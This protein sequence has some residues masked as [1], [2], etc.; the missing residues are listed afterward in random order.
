MDPYALGPDSIPWA[1]RA[2]LLVVYGLGSAWWVRAVG[3]HMRA[4][5]LPA[6]LLA[7]VL[8]ANAAV[9]L[10]FEPDKEVLS[11]AVLSFIF[12]WLANAKM[13]AFYLGRGPLARHLDSGFLPFAAFLLLPLLPKDTAHGEGLRDKEATARRVSSKHATLALGKAVLLMAVCLALANV[14]MPH[15]P[16]DLLY[17]LG[18]YGLLG[19]IMDGTCS[20][21]CMFGLELAPH[22]DKPWLSTSV[23]EFW[24]R[25]WNL[26]AADSLRALAF[27]P[28]REGRLF[29]VSPKPAQPRSASSHLLATM[30]GVLLTFALSGLFHGATFWHLTRTFGWRWLAFFCLQGPLVIIERF[31]VRRLWPKMPQIVAILYAIA[32]LE[33]GGRYLFIAPAEDMGLDR[34]VVK[35]ILDL[36]AGMFGS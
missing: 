6:A 23:A 22:F 20:L 24:G 4:G 28:L 17:A 30:V 35:A 7:P 25:R 29:R 3:Q 15:V 2:A 31:I 12:S 21:T 27:D 11:I 32:A 14:D 33:L 1:I 16:R 34:K 9:P 26:V 18:M 5:L 36:G 19:V 8:I 13:V 10:M